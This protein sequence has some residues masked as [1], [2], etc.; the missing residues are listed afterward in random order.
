MKTNYSYT[1]SFSDTK[2]KIAN[3]K[4][5][6]FGNHEINTFK[7]TWFIE[8]KNKTISLSHMYLMSIQKLCHLHF[9]SF[10]SL[11]NRVYWMKRKI[12]YLLLKTNG[13][14]VTFFSCVHTLTCNSKK[15][16]W[17]SL[18]KHILEKFGKKKT[19]FPHTDYKLN[20][21]SILS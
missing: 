14:D 9:Y 5:N 10:F 13:N 15:T 12:I 20:N 4:L 3:F 1:S 18:W 16:K 6:F 7:I 11:F 19:E 21:F 8:S 2:E 17:M